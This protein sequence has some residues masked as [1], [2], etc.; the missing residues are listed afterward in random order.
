MPSR[1]ALTSVE[2]QWGPIG[3]VEV[4][5]E[6]FEQCS[7]AIR[8]EIGVAQRYIK[9]IPILYRRTVCLGATFGYTV[10]GCERGNVIVLHAHHVNGLHGVKTSI[11]VQARNQSE[12]LRRT[13]SVFQRREHDEESFLSQ[14]VFRNSPCAA[15]FA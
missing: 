3:N 6:G 15:S 13:D 8:R 9:G 5:L 11:V 14:R 12:F 4:E 7:P 2:Y 1:T 10:T